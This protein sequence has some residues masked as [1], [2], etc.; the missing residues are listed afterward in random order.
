MDDAARLGGMT[1]YVADEAFASAFVELHVP[2][3]RFGYLVCGDRGVAEDVVVGAFAKA[4]PHFRAGRIENLEA[5]LR[6][7]IVNQACSWRSR[8]LRRRADAS[9]IGDPPAPDDQQPAETRLVLWP[10][11]A[12]LSVR[13]RATIVLR[14]FDGLS[15]TET[16]AVLGVTEGTVKSQCSKAL[17]RL[18]DWL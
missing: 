3:L 11:I 7:S 18:R 4:L 1:G 10:H 6:R 8:V 2:L 15:V 16:A 5:Y 17:D 13:Q 12:R 9:L 14:Y